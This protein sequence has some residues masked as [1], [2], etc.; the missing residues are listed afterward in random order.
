MKD[1]FFLS[2]VAN[3][4]MGQSPDS[5]SCNQQEDGLPFLQGCGEFGDKTPIVKNY[6]K[7]P[8]KISPKDSILISVRAPVG[9]INLAD[10]DYVIGR[11]LAGI[12]AKNTNRDFLY[13]SI[14]QFKN[15]L[16]RVSQG[17]TFE[18]INS[19]DLHNFTINKFSPNEE[20]MIA[21]ILSTCDSVIEQ[22]ES[23]IAKYQAIKQGMMHDLFTRGIDITTGKL[24]PK[25]EDAPE[26]YKQSELGWIPKDW[27]VCSLESLTIKI[28]DGLHGTPKYVDNSMFHFINGNN[29]KDGQICITQNTNCV[30]EDEYKLHGKDLAINTILFSINGT[31]GNIAFY[32]GETVV[33]GKSA[34]YISFVNKDLMEFVYHTLQTDLVYNFYELALTGSTIKN[35]S[36]TSIRNTPILL[37]NNDGEYKS[38]TNKLNTIVAKI[39]S[40]Q[41]TLSKYQKL[42]QGLMQD[43]LT[44]KVEVLVDEEQVV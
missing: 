34:A 15:Q 31:I 38:I 4:I 41:S 18:A 27:E 20:I 32:Q 5:T 10:Q 14:L 21:K 22:T 7:S 37:P 9:D 16:R 44:G 23:A 36:L 8:K 1:K 30:S 19:K 43:L 29:L 28:G 33:L 11:G 24:R 17:S 12:V 39:T 40:E 25:Q 26:L 13:Y 6:C 3:F 35:L 42:K 2:D